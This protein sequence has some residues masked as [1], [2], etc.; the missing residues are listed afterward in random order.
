MKK[1]NKK[2]FT[3]IEL[4][5]VV[6]IIAI[7]AAIALPKYLRAVEKSRVSEA[8]T[9]MGTIHHAQSI[10]HIMHAPDYST[11]F[12][13]LDID[14]IGGSVSNDTYTTDTFVYTLGSDRVT[15]ERRNSDA[16]VV[17][18][19]YEDGSLCCTN[20]TDASFDICSTLSSEGT[21]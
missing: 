11:D 9:I 2:G 19:V 4:L 14:L 17:G 20:G 13:E 16:Y 12:S 15:A 6:L 3:L 10:Y 7:L 1:L 5:V 8:K 21:C 18:I